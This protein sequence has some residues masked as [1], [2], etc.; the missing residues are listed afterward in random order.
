MSA[1]Q[2]T[3]NHIEQLRIASKELADKMHAL[4][5][6]YKKQE[7]PYTKLSGRSSLM[8]LGSV[9]HTTWSTRSLWRKSL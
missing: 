3:V 7:R 6:Q 5:V 2:E 1:I 8:P 4:E 9:S